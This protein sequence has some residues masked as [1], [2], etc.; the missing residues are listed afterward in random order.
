[1]KDLV[2][3]IMPTYNSSATLQRSVDSIL[4][5]TYTNIEL[6]I[7]DDCSKDNTADLIRSIAEADSRVHPT[8]LTSNFGPGYARNDAI[9]RAKGRYIAFCD[10]D[11]RWFPDKLEK[12]IAFMN[13]KQCALSY[14]SYLVCD[15]NDNDVGIVVA[16]ERIDLSM[17]KR[18]NKI[19]CLTAI[20][21]TQLLGQKYYMPTLRKRQDWALFLTILMKCGVACGITYPLAYYRITT[22]SV[23]SNKFSLVK[24]NVRVYQQILGYSKFKSYCYFLFCF[25]PSYS[26]KVLK[27]KVNSIKYIAKLKEMKKNKNR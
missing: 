3:V 4:N 5:Q 11:D 20:Y 15:E 12:Q 10:S 25:F 23:S 14:T 18:D 9:K 6:L 24:Y 27:N 17:L 22:D 19:G 13:E 21:D 7:T 1:M 8:L 26:L 16:P 2:S